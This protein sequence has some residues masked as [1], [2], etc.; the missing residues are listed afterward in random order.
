MNKFIL[1]AVLSLTAF[2]VYASCTTSTISTPDGKFMVCTTCCNGGN[3]NTTC[4]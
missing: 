1:T 3:C 4:F 2:S